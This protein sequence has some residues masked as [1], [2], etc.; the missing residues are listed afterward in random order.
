ML[1]KYGHLLNVTAQIKLRSG[2]QMTCPLSSI[3]W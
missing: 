1:E 3:S 2:T